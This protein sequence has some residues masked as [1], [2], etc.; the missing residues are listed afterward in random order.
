M[1]I[2]QY[3]V[4]L[5]NSNLFNLLS[6]ICIGDL[7]DNSE[8]I[9]KMTGSKR[10]FIVQSTCHKDVDITFSETKLKMGEGG[11]TSDCLFISPVYY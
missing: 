11:M 7:L 8:I 6:K 2:L 4:M 10:G 9:N 5:Y 3:R 1:K